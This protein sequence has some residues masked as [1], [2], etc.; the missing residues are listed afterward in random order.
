MGLLDI[1]M[2]GMDTPEGQG[3]LSAAFSLMSA[4]K[5]P[6]QRGAMA[7]ALGDAG[8]QYLGTTNDARNQSQRRAMGDLQMQAQQMQLEAAR[9]AQAQEE[10]NRQL[11]R[12]AF[13]P[14][15]SQ[16]ALQGGGGPTMANAD[17]IG[18]MPKYSPLSILQG[19]GDFSALKQGMELNSALNPAPK[20]TAYKP[21][22]MIFKDG[23]MSKPAFAVP[24]KPEAL[25]SAVREFQFGQSNPAFNQWLLNQNAVKGTRVNVSNITKQEGEEAKTVG[26]YFGDAYANIQQ[27]GFGAQSKINRYTRLDQLLAGVSTGKF[28]ATGLEVAKAASSLGLNIDPNMA[29]KEAAQALSSEIALELRNPSGGAGM[30]GAMSDADRQFLANMVP[31]LATTPNGRKLMMDTAIKLADRDKDV[32]RMARNYRQKHGTINEGFYNELAAYSEANPLFGN[33][34]AQTNGG[35][36][37][38]K[39]PTANASNKGKYLTDTA[40]GKRFRSNGMSWVEER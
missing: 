12:D 16:G 19:G 4:Q 36:A 5:L 20:Y 2:P 34:A 28:A 24:D 21:G 27:A 1:N 38:S 32:A 22:D 39:M 25:P 29:N 14:T 8:R 31:G 35:Q 18:T 30:P 10:R 15:T 13:S 26:K 7:G 33:V 37:F 6:G 9:K 23:D 17:K 11:L 40:T 3:L